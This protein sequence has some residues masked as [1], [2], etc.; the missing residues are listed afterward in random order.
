MKRQTVFTLGILVFL[1]AGAFAAETLPQIQKKIIEK[2]KENKE[3]EEKS[4]KLVDE[5]SSFKKDLIK[6]TQDLQKKEKDLLMA[7]Q[8]IALLGEEKDSLKSNLQQSYKNSGGLIKAAYYYQ[9]PSFTQVALISD[10]IAASRSAMVMRTVTRLL[11]IQA[12]DYKTKLSDVQSIEG[13]LVQ[14]KSETKK[15]L[16]EI[17]DKKQNINALIEQK[18]R[19]YQETEQTRKAKEKELQTLAQQAKNLEDLMRKIEKRAEG[20][21]AR[22]QKTAAASTRLP[23]GM[24][25]PVAGRILTAF[26]QK[27]DLNAASD[28]IAFSVTSGAIVSAPLG[29]HVKFAGPFQKF[30][31]VLII[32][33]AAGYHSLIAGLG[34]ID[35]EV[36]AR[37]AAGEPVGA[38]PDGG[39]TQRIYYELR[40]NG[41][42]INPQK[43]AIAQQKTSR[44]RT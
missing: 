37:L 7:E 15:I 23:G 21:S 38:A 10:P 40:H 3:L 12:A 32:E 26:G 22:M 34:R 5:I 28:G 43:A 36:D 19:S 8:K 16:N 11:Q 44:K 14:T 18:K 9:K 42:P 41:E 27:D 4:S 35:T 17:K 20:K 1:N 24:H 33:H 31:R 6:S 13:L 30:G 2:Q 25:M 39:G 29:G